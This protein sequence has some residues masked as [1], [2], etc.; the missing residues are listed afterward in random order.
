MP[1]F[2]PPTLPN[3]SLKHRNCCESRLHMSRASGRVCVF[4]FSSKTDI[5]LLEQWRLLCSMSR[6]IRKVLMKDVTLSRSKTRQYRFLFSHQ[7]NQVHRN[8]PSSSSTACPLP[9]H[10]DYHPQRSGA[11]LGASVLVLLSAFV[12]ALATQDICCANAE[13]LSRCVLGVIDKKKVWHQLIQRGK[14]VRS[15]SIEQR[16]L[17]DC[18]GC[19]DDYGGSC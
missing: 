8:T 2:V 18:L 9:P 12:H 4:S 10:P 17:Y 14:E 11:V 5:E 3:R 1:A 15:C 19:G 13:H 6:R 16:R 7:G